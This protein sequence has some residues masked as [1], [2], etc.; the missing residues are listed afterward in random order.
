[1]WVLTRISG[2]GDLTRAGLA[3]AGLRLAVG[4]RLTT[5]RPYD[6]LTPDR[7]RAMVR[8]LAATRLPV[9]GEY[10]RAIRSLAVAYV[11]EARYAS[12]P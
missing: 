2:A 5:G 7:R 3:A 9:A 1:M 8:W 6:R 12:V 4:V 10:V 11:Y